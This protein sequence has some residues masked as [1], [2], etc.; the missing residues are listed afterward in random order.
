MQQPALW[1]V[2]PP[3]RTLVSKHRHALTCWSPH[4]VDRFHF[5]FV[6]IVQSTGTVLVCTVIT[7]GLRADGPC[8]PHRHWQ[9]MKFT[10]WKLS[11]LFII[12]CSRNFLKQADFHWRQTE[13]FLLLWQMFYLKGSECC[14]SL[15][16][17]Q[18][19]REMEQDGDVSAMEKRFRGKATIK[20]KA[21]IKRVR[22]AYSDPSLILVRSKVRGS[23]SCC[24]LMWQSSDW[25]WSSVFL[26]KFVVWSQGA[27]ISLF[28]DVIFL[29]CKTYVGFFNHKTKQLSPRSTWKTKRQPKAGLG[30]VLGD[31]SFHLKPTTTDINCECKNDKALTKTNIA[32]EI[33]PALSTLTHR[34]LSL[35]SLALSLHLCRSARCLSSI[36]SPEKRQTSQ[37]PL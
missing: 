16:Q 11:A 18:T 7:F 36:D 22:L 9:V 19:V 12:V 21:I 2:L 37:P 32:S 3:K 27:G 30:V 5:I 14:K 33:A 23:Y 13:M 25:D 28:T 1:A 20:K 34:R 35:R 29:H 15:Q 4:T 8:W 31:A 10:S 24:F 17:I 26:T 6:V